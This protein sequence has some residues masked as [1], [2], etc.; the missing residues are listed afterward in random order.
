MTIA[1]MEKI[2]LL[3]QAVLLLIVEALLAPFVSVSNKAARN[4]FRRQIY[5][6]VFFGFVLHCNTLFDDEQK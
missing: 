1:Q 4:A 5:N 2:D 6:L 3:F